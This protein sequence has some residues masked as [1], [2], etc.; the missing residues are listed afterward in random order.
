M[1]VEAH[2][3]NH[4]KR[5]ELS[6]YPIVALMRA[7]IENIRILDRRTD[8]KLTV[9]AMDSTINTCNTYNPWSVLWPRYVWV[10]N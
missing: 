8:N 6:C 1:R 2:K 3:I 5:R 7:G 9:C 4:N 10:K